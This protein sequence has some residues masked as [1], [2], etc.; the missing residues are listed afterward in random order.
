MAA[1]HRG[2]RPP[3]PCAGFPTIAA[4]HR[5]GRPPPPSSPQKNSR[6]ADPAWLGG[7]GV[8]R[9]RPTSAVIH[10]YLN[11]S[12]PPAELTAARILPRPT[13]MKRRRFTL[14][15]VKSRGSRWGSA[16]DA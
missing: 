12:L 15:L 6:A 1:A 5:R 16:G 9:R 11:A 8:M 2:G 14:G 7:S 13:Q 10:G 4:A 3:P